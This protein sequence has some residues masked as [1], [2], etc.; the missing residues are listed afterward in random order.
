MLP[1][2]FVQNSIAFIKFD[3]L[4]DYDL[5][6]ITDII[7]DVLGTCNF[8]YSICG[9]Y[10]RD[11]DGY[12]CLHLNNGHNIKTIHQLLA[13]PKLITSVVKAIIF[14]NVIELYDVCTLY[15][16]RNKGYMKSLMAELMR[17]FGKKDLWIGVHF[18]HSNFEKITEF[19]TA[20]GFGNPEKVNKTTQG[21]ILPKSVLSMSYPTL[22]S[23][24]QVQRKIKDITDT[25]SMDMNNNY[26]ENFLV[27]SN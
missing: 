22:Q 18:D 10:T 9:F 1:F 7:K 8:G 24:A 2:F 12:F 4:R 5:V 21:T 19:Y 3:L 11:C 14:P 26:I 15:V 16:H 17:T 25:L 27:F 20:F 6:P 23:K 13:Q